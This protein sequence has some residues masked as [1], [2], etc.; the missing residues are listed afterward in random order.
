M[1]F[2]DYKTRFNKE[3]AFFEDQKKI[4]IHGVAEGH[5]KIQ[6]QKETFLAC[7]K[8]YKSSR[9]IFSFGI[10]T[11]P[12]FSEGID[13]SFTLIFEPLPNDCTNFNLQSVPDGGSWKVY[14]FDRNK[15]DVYIFSISE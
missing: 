15:E 14:D 6:L 8:N 7:Y 9:L 3:N 11:Y 5:H 1:I 12:N 2:E 10:R 4:I 13:Q